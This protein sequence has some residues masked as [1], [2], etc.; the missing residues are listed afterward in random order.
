MK[1]SGWG[2]VPVW[3]DSRVG[4]VWVHLVSVPNPTLGAVATGRPAL[5]FPALL[6]APTTASRSMQTSRSTWA[7][8]HQ[9]GFLWAR[10]C[11]GHGHPD[12]FNVLYRNLHRS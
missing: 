12:H 5:A 8:R 4:S 6:P 7:R 10:R 2:L 1:I 11:R 3:E 9:R